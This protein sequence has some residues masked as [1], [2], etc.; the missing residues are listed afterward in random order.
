[1]ICFL[2][3]SCWVQIYLGGDACLLSSPG[4]LHQGIVSRSLASTGPY[5]CIPNVF[6]SPSVWWSGLGLNIGQIRTGRLSQRDSRD[7]LLLANFVS[8]KFTFVSRE[9]IKKTPGSSL[10]SDVF[11]LMKISYPKIS[12][13]SGLMGLLTCEH[14]NGQLA[15]SNNYLGRV[16][17]TADKLNLF[18]TRV[19]ILGPGPV[20]RWL[21]TFYNAASN[22]HIPWAQYFKR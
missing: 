8:D 19:V 15:K 13:I 16:V 22:I 3:P 5:C 20:P 12:R 4:Q 21:L 14:A 1:M 18:I 17:P 11:F 6:Y 10:H 2:K 7:G 9:V